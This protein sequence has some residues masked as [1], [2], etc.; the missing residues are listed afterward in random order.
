MLNLHPII[1]LLFSSAKKNFRVTFPNG[2]TDIKNDQIVSESV[3]M[4]EGVCSE[5]VFR[6]GAMERSSIEFDAV[7]I[8][9]ITGQTIACYLELD[10]SSL[11]A[12]E[13]NAVDDAQY[14]GE[15]VRSASSD[16]GYP[17]YRIP[18]GGY[19]VQSADRAQGSHDRR[20]VSA[21]SRAPWAWSPVERARL[22]TW[23]GATPNTTRKESP[24]DLIYANLGF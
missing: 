16:L 17:F 15:L 1:E 5:N 19:I 23:Y 3:K 21:M 4:S 8:S 2:G 9:D 13:L 18:Y 22:D 10:C 14:D 7:G 20:H 6:F 24:K 11:S 12:A